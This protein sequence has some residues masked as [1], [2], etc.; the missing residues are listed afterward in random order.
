[1]NTRRYSVIWGLLFSFAVL[2][3]LW[4][5]FPRVAVAQDDEPAAE[6]GADEGPAAP[7]KAAAKGGDQ[8][9][10]AAPAEENTLMWLI[11]TSGW[12]GA[13]ILV[14]SIY[15][16][17][18]SVRM[19]MELRPEILAPPEVIEE[20]EKLMQGRDFTG[21]Y[22]R[23]KGDN[24]F[25]STV[26]AAGIAE[27]PNGLPDARDAM[28]RVGEVNTIGLER[29]ISMLA[30][31]GTLGPMIGLLGTLMGMIESFS[32]IATSGTQLKASEVA[33]GISKA[34]VLTFEGVALSVPAIYLFALFRNRI[35]SYGATTMLDADA[36]VRRLYAVMK[37]KPA[38]AP[39]AAPAP[40]VRT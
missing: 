23:L 27:L 29:K 12:I 18:T 8:A 36:F 11:R 4:A 30:V 21:L 19:F 9:G 35:S 26:V 28:E 2:S 33:S 38:A 32:S 16:V 1:M 22:K 7:A 39:A 25:F 20:A 3:L 13:V 34:L 14:L 6:E 17:A 40:P 31:I 10:D 15:F 37:S 5:Q 24:S